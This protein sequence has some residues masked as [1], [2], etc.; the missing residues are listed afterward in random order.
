MPRKALTLREVIDTLEAHY[1]PP[2]GPESTDPFELI[3]FEN[4]GYLVDDARR[5]E[6][7]TAFKRHFGTK[8]ANIRNSPIAAIAQVIKRG[9][10]QPEH[11]AEKLKDAA[12]IALT[13]FNGNLRSVLALPE[14][15]ARKALKKFPG[16]GEPG[17]DKLL[18]FTGTLP[19]LALESNGLRT[20]LRLGFGKESPNYAKTYRSVQDAL[21]NQI[22]D[23]CE[24]LIA[25][26]QL[27]R[28]HGQTLCKRA[29]PLCAECPLR[30]RC[31][32]APKTLASG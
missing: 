7:W 19:V 12:E 4:V 16:I 21:K 28:Q 29:R 10:M 18:L 6:V 1:G 3:L 32:A 27:L 25:A 17:A 2:R 26:H 20:L 30:S 9:G 31:P 15:Q 23:D 13:D 5:L 8:P 22:G 11:R 14:K 24:W